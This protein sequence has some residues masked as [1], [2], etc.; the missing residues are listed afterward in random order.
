MTMPRN[1]DEAIQK[2]QLYNIIY[3]QLGYLYIILPNGP[4]SQSGDKDVAMTISR[5]LRVRDF[6]S[7]GI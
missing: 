6:M 1:E 4:R 7:R 5:E 2:E 3:S